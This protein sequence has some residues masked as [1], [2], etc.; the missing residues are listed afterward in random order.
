MWGYIISLLSWAALRVTL[1]DRFWWLFLINS[2]VPYYFLFLIPALVLVFVFRHKL[3]WVGLLV[4]SG[5]WAVVYGHLFLPQFTVQDKSEQAL[6]VMTYNVMGLNVDSES[7]FSTIRSSDADLVMLQELNS[8]MSASIQTGLAESYPYQLLEP[9]GGPDG[10]GIISRYPFEP[11]GE[12]LQGVWVGTPQVITLDFSG[13]SV[14]VLNVHTFAS[15]EPGS[16]VWTIDGREEQARIL[17]N[18]VEQHSAP[19]IVGA[20]FNA[21]DQHDAYDIVTVQLKDAWREAGWGFG[22]TFPAG[23]PYSQA[24]GIPIPSWIVRIDYLFHSE[25]WEAIS[26]ETGP[27]DGTSDHRPVIATLRLKDNE[28][29]K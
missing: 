28:A 20:D 1:D 12:P 24:T 22:H 11:S 2:F 23:M 8:S 26:A 10:M 21:T 27:W 17:A 9:R 18:Y 19:I 3:T 4:G 13:T 14:M 15:I 5:L 25:H 29:A 7:V 16:F 6:S